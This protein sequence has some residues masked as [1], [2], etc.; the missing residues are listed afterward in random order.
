[1]QWHEFLAIPNGTRIL[2]HSYDQCVA[3]AN[4][5]HEQVIGGSFV[6]VGSAYQWYTQ[7][8]NYPQIHSKY[9]QLHPGA[10]PEPGDIFVSRGG[11]YNSVDGH[12]G[13]V[14]RAWDGAT[15]GTKE[16]NAERNRYSYQTYNRSKA[17]MLGY[18]RP[19]VS[20]IPQPEPLDEREDDMY[21]IAAMSNGAAFLWNMAT[22]EYRHIDTDADMARFNQALKMYRFKDIA[23][24]DAFKAKYPFKLIITAGSVNVDPAAIAKAVNDEASRRLQG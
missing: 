20:P 12:I 4:L 1:M 3:L 23:E 15:F 2:N 8:A 6:P 24:F 17:N 13:V 14:I 22:N 16:Q 5:Y 11:I 7:Y 18:L 10:N 19:K 21:S 9:V